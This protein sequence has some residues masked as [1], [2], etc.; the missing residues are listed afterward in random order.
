MR[1]RRWE[2]KSRNT[3]TNLA[4]NGD[5]REKPQGGSNLPPGWSAWQDEK[6]PTGKF[7][8]VES[9]GNG[10]ARAAKVAWG[11]FIQNITAAPGQIFVVQAACRARGAT[12]P[13]LT[14]RWQTS[15]HKWTHEEDDRPFDFR[16]GAGD[17]R[18]A[19]GVVTVPSDAA[20]LVVL[21][22]VRGQATEEDVCWFDNIE[23]YHLE[24]ANL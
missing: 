22:D 15:D 24:D 13:S 9:T 4:V 6:H 17:W 2:L 11:C 3:A 14:I 18:N 19:F 23:V 12:M 1:R 16:P 20:Q 10:A 21:L 7:D 8:W 5:F